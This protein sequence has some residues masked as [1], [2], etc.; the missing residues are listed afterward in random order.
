[1][2]IICNKKIICKLHCALCAAQGAKLVVPDE[3]GAFRVQGRC[4]AAACAGAR[5]DHRAAP[6]CAERQ[7]ALSPASLPACNSAK[8]RDFSPVQFHIRQIQQVL[9]DVTLS[10]HKNQNETQETRKKMFMSSPS[11]PKHGS[12]QQLSL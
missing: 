12:L 4:T 2:K 5:P 1:M 6:A 7:A 3:A 9:A 11:K 10:K 8:L